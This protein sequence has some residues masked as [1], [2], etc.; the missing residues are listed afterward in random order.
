MTEKE[1]KR[2]LI[3]LSKNDDKAAETY[4]RWLRSSQ[5]KLIIDLMSSYLANPTILESYSGC[6]PKTAEEALYARGVAKGFELA[7]RFMQNAEVM[8]PVGEIDEIEETFT[9]EM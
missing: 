4:Q 7:L 5:T 3:G 2:Y 6:V 8:A 1:A 9:E